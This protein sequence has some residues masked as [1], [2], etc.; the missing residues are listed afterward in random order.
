MSGSELSASTDLL[1]GAGQ[2]LVTV[3]SRLRWVRLSKYCEQ[4]GDTP[5]AVKARRRRAQWTDG[6]HCRLAQDGNLWVNLDE[7]N[8]WVESHRMEEP[9]T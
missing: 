9:P 8:A 3:Q 5:A 7:V 2:V 4:T 6:L 1:G